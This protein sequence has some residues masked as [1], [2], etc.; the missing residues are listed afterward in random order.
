MS[1]VIEREEARLDRPSMTAG[2]TAIKARGCPPIFFENRF[3]PRPLRGASLRSAALTAAPPP[4]PQTP[5]SM[6]RTEAL[7]VK[8]D[9]S[10]S[11]GTAS[12]NVV[13]RVM[14]ALVSG[15]EVEF[16]RGVG[17]ALAHR[18]LE[19][20]EADFR[21][22]ARVEERWIGAYESTDNEDFELDRIAICGRLDGKWFCATMLVDGDGQAHG[23]MGCR[24]FRSMVRAR[25][26]MLHAH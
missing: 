13:D 11:I 19:A 16:G 21:W 4:V 5:F 9:M 14:A 18:F 2:G 3:P 17:E 15:L 1:R 10:Q 20:E 12:A 24:Q 25:D 6:V 8:M 22:D 7:E 26:A 23:M